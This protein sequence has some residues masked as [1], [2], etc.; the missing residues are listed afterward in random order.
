MIY[1]FILGALFFTTT[2]AFELPK[3]SKYQQ[4]LEKAEERATE[5]ESES[6]ERSKKAYQLQ[7]QATEKQ[8][9]LREKAELRT[10]ESPQAA[11]KRQFEAKARERQE[12]FAQKQEERIAKAKRIEEE[13]GLKPIE[14]VTFSDEEIKNNIEEMFIRLLN[15]YSDTT[16]PDK[17]ILNKNYELVDKD[18]NNPAKEDLRKK[19]AIFLND[20]SKKIDILRLS[21]DI[22]K[23]LDEG[24]IEEQIT[25]KDNITKLLNGL[26]DIY[27]RVLSLKTLDPKVKQQLEDQRIT[28]TK[29]HMKLGLDKK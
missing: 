16:K 4:R 15:N 23:Y 10:L 11:A 3:K 6:I 14:V 2:S 13:L 19:V 1:V 20:F 17:Y 25:L 21:P 22:E 12:A 8:A 26:T 27:T 7:T 28:V 18:L 29:L 9:A 24:R 5:L